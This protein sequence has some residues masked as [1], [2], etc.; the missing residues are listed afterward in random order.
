MLDQIDPSWLGTLQP[1]S[2]QLERINK[3]I[4]QEEIAPAFENVYRVF[5]FPISHYR[6]VIVG[7]DPYPTRGYANGLA[8]SVNVKVSKWPASLRNIFSEYV[9]DTGF[10]SPTTGD[11]SS[12]ANNGVALIN[13]A[14]TLNLSDKRAHLNIGWSAITQAAV[15]AL[16]QKNAVAILW[17]SHAQKIGNEFESERKIQSVHPSPLSAYRGFFGSKPFSKCNELLIQSGQLPIDWRL[18]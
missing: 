3:R 14:L 9:T 1:F 7:Q 12:W 11:L 15:S 10:E 17:G 4:S 2:A 5:N 8:F 13:S 16:A 6:A 18:P